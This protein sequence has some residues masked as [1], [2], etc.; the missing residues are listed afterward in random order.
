MITIIDTIR[1]I[2]EWIEANFGEPPITKDIQEGFDRPGT[3]VQP[4][5]MS[6]SKDSQLRVDEYTIEITRF[7]ELNYRGYLELLRYQAAFTELLES[8]I[9]V[10]S[11]FLLYPEEV[12]FELDRDDMYLV[13]TFDVKN[14]QLVEEVIDAPTME[15]LEL[16]QIEE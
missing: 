11:L 7:S 5:E 15:E 16:D 14:I 13:V 9:P 12:E 3:Y 8:P 1:G 6:T 10:D 2:S 4:V